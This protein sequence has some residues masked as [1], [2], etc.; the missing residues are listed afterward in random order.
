MGAVGLIDEYSRRMEG[1][2]PWLYT[3][4]TRAAKFLIIQAP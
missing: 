2:R 3:G 4:V 1:R